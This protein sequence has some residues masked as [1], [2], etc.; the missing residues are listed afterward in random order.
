MNIK[1]TLYLTVLISIFVCLSFIVMG[2]SKSSNV[3]TVTFTVTDF[4]DNPLAGGK[5]VSEEEPAN[6]LKL[7]GLTDDVGQVK[8]TNVISGQY[9]FYINRFDYEL[10]DLTITID[11]NHNSFTVKLEKTP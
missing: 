2:C 3:A 1:I 4:N 11:K 10:Q 9:S 7:T 6:Q 5:V 8:F